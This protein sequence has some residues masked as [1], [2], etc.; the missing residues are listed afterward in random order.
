MMRNLTIA[1]SLALAL[2]AA[3]CTSKANTGETTPPAPPASDCP[4]PGTEGAALADPEKCPDQSQPPSP[5]VCNSGPDDKRCP[6]QNQ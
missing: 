1:T 6:D 5:E 2:L 4:E 3:G